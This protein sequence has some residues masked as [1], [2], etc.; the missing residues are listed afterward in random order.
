[1]PIDHNFDTIQNFHQVNQVLSQYVRK[2][3]KSGSYTLDRMIKLMDFLGNPQEKLKI[4]HIAGT[5]GKTSTAY[6]VS[7]L[8]QTA[9]Y[10]IGLTVSPHVDQVNERAQINLR[11]LDESTYCRELTEF[12]QIIQA[13]GITPSYYELL[14]A[15]AFW[16]FERRQVDY[17]VIEVGLGG[18][19]DGTNVVNRPDK[20]AVITDIGFDHTHILG[21]T[22]AKIA[23]EKAGIIQ[24]GNTVFTHDQAPEIISVIK[25]A[26]IKQKAEVKTIEHNENEIDEKFLKDL[27]LFQRHN[28][29]LAKA[30][31][32]YIL[33]SE[34]KLLEADYLTYAAQIRIP[35]RMEIITF[36]Q[37]KVIF[38]AAHNEQ[39]LQALAEAVKYKFPDQKI[40]L[41]VSFS[42]QDTEKL[43]NRF[44]IL[45]SLNSE[46]IITR[47]TK[48]QDEI[49]PP[50]K[51]QLLEKL[52][53]QAGFSK[54]NINTNPL[55][56]FQQLLN[57]EE[58]VLLVTGSFFLINE[59][60][61][62]LEVA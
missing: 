58:Q 61:P 60:H 51:L 52:S 41:L 4:I 43:K 11:P 32:G 50:K 14:V 15:F 24:P 23:S 59:I 26:A 12:L 37:K 33:D 56:A 28:F 38:D 21:N 22:L 45:N 17:A 3:P 54:V 18:R 47:Y 62:L 49:K 29:Q 20:I 19:L 6:Y 16:L 53:Q 55:D 46:I 27:P 9:G 42:G 48:F 10:N 36:N 30:V 13:S 34:K 7:A 31:A 57:L 35:A 40:G 25:Q 44:Q 2:N 39:K 8:L 1:M 5:S